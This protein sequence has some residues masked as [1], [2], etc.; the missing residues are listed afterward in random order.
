MKYYILALLLASSAV[1]ASMIRNTFTDKRKVAAPDA[2]G[3]FSQ[4]NC[5]AECC[6]CAGCCACPCSG[7]GGG[8]SGDSAA[9]EAA[10]KAVEAVEDMKKQ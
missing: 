8:G 10:N 1:E 6:P 2:K 9:I 5:A 4:V 3:H 7:G